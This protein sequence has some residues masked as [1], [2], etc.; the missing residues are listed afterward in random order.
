MNK[1]VLMLLAIMGV[2]WLVAPALAQTYILVETKPYKLDCPNLKWSVDPQKDATPW[3]L[4]YKKGSNDI[5]L[6]WKHANWNPNTGK[7]EI[8]LSIGSVNEGK[9]RFDLVDRSSMTLIGQVEASTSAGTMGFKTMKLT[10][11][12]SGA[13]SDPPT[14]TLG[15]I[16]DDAADC[17]QSITDYTFKLQSSVR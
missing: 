8:A 6:S 2:A 16:L 4:R 15:I 11:R 10:P 12:R 3:K 5:V 14:F 1:T 13:D 17:R 7:V 9:V